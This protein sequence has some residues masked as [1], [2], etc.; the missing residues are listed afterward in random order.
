MSSPS[1]IAAGVLKELER[2]QEAPATY[3][4]VLAIR[5][6]YALTLLTAARSSVISGVLIRHWRATAK[7]WR[8]VPIM[9]TYSTT[10]AWL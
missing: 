4:K 2:Y 9:P 3:E 5:P 1:T 7:C 10:E 6:G 8:C